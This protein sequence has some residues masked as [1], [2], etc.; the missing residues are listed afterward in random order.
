MLENV[1]IAVV[2][3]AALFFTARHLAKIL[4]AKDGACEGCAGCGQAS[5]CLATAGNH[6]TKKQKQQKRK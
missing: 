5:A 4:R 3:C 1:M 6:E 2:V